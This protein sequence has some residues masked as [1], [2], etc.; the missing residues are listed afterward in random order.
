MKTRMKTRMKRLMLATLSSLLLTA[1]LPPSPAMAAKVMEIDADNLVRGAGFL[2]DTLGLT[3]NQQTLWQQVAARSAGLL[4]ARQTRRDKL[5]AALKAQLQGPAQELRTLAGA[6]ALEADA[7]A[8]ENAELR[9]LWLTVNDAL[10]DRQRE[11]VNQFL[12]SQ[13]DRVDA[14]ERAAERGPGAGRGEPPQGGQR[15]QKPGGD[16]NGA[17]F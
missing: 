14:P 11:T 1:A 13:L 2:K 16:M 7:T 17:R 12:V 8:R 6:I 15:R 5:Q 9:E 3:P 4:R 10:D